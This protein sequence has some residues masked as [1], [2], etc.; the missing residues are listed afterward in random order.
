MAAGGALMAY[1]RPATRPSCYFVLAGSR[2]A[3]LASRR[4]SL[5]LRWRLAISSG[6]S[7]PLAVFSS[8]RRSSAAVTGA[9]AAGRR[10]P[11]RCTWRRAEHRRQCTSGRAA[12][13]WAHPRGHVAG[14][15]VLLPVSPRHDILL[16]VRS[17][18]GRLRVDIDIPADPQEARTQAFRDDLPQPPIP[19][20]HLGVHE[21]NLR[22]DGYSFLATSGPVMR[23][24]NGKVA[25]M[26]PRETAIPAAVMGDKGYL[27]RGRHARRPQPFR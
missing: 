26:M 12:R 4:A 24:S 10:N 18:K 13:T 6:G 27:V 7:Q 22:L 19:H 17:T 21:V 20:S 3:R 5:A 11:R 16:A 1:R 23:V 8:A 9:P 15:D 2:A 14:R 25:A